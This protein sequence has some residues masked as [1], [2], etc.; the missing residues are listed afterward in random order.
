MNAAIT[1][2][3]KQQQNDVPFK[4]VKPK[5]GMN[6][7][8]VFH[9]LLYLNFFPHSGF[10]AKTKNLITSQKIF[11]NICHTTIIP[12]PADVTEAELTQILDSDEPS[13]F[14]IPLSLGEGHEEIDKCMLYSFC[15]CSF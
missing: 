7:R 13:T 9:I 5:P 8:L 4:T 10:C 6:G 12:A 15:S 2:R 1:E 3:D 11:I 14:R